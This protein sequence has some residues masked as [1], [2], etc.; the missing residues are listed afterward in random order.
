[1]VGSAIKETPK[2]ENNEIKFESKRKTLFTV[3]SWWFPKL[4]DTDDDF[5]NI[6]VGEW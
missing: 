2:T 5:S 6:S 1:V 4:S 3:P